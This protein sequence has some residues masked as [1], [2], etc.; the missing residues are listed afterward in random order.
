MTNGLGNK[1]KFQMKYFLNAYY[2]Q[3]TPTQAEDKPLFSADLT[4][5]LWEVIKVMIQRKNLYP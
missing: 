1:F 2:T 5:P 4:L 3:D